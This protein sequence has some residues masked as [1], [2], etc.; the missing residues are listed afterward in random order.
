MW[1]LAIMRSTGGFFPFIRPIMFA[2]RFA[3]AKVMHCRYMPY[4][5]STECQFQYFPHIIIFN[6]VFHPVFMGALTKDTHLLQE[7]TWN[8]R[9]THSRHAEAKRGK[10]IYSC[11]YLSKIV[12]KNLSLLDQALL[13]KLELS[14]V[15][16]FTPRGQVVERSIECWRSRHRRSG[17]GWGPPQVARQVWISRSRC[18]S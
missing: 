8:K 9:L 3:L 2:R 11:K 5:P 15:Q 6:L 7:L 12:C 10:F 13:G 1:R 18:H 17:C 4:L 16:D 14:N